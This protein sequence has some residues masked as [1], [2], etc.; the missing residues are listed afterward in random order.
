MFL[1]YLQIFPMA[2]IFRQGVMGP[3]ERRVGVQVFLVVFSVAQY[4]PFA[5]VYWFWMICRACGR[6]ICQEQRKFPEMEKLA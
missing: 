3:P 2:D 5:P 6:P 4:G 1:P